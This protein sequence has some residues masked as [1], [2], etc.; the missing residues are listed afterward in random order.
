MIEVV[1][2]NRDLYDRMMGYILKTET[3]DF[4]VMPSEFTDWLKDS[5]NMCNKKT[6]DEYNTKKIKRITFYE[7]LKAL[8]EADASIL[9]H[10]P[11]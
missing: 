9:R 5:L 2:E 10:N 6:I 3:G 7:I 11:K 4:Q 8:K 1:L